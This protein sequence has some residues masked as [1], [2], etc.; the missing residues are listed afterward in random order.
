VCAID[1]NPPTSPISTLPPARL[2]AQ[3]DAYKPIPD[4]AVN[5]RQTLDENIAD[6]GGISAAYHEYRASLASLSTVDVRAMRSLTYSSRSVFS[7]KWPINAQRAS[8]RG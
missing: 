2:A 7:A 4:L 3:Y 6:L 1:G 5:G 8:E